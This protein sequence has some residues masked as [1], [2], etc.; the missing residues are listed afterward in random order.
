MVTNKFS[1]NVGG[2][3]DKVF[4]PD[5]GA[6]DSHSAAR[7]DGPVSSKAPAQ[8]RGESH[9]DK[10]AGREKKSQRESAKAKK[11]QDSNKPR[12]PAAEFFA[13]NGIM[14]EQVAPLRP[15]GPARPV[16][17]NGQKQPLRPAEGHSWAAV[18][19]LPAE[20]P[21]ASTEGRLGRAVG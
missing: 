21:V 10:A 3:A 8:P 18:A 19:A 9:A 16:D 4:P 20:G 11:G 5:A 17:E 2:K 13:L 15:G 14:P 1:A 6:A 12:D 7:K